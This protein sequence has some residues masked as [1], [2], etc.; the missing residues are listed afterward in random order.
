MDCATIKYDNAGNEKWVAR[1]DGS[2]HLDDRAFDIVV[3]PFYSV[4]ITGSV[5][6]E[7]N[8]LFG[9]DHTD[10]LIIRYDSSGTK[11]WDATFGGKPAKNDVGHAIIADDEGTVY[12]AGEVILSDVNI[13]YITL[14]YD[15]SGSRD[16]YQ[17]W[18]GPSDET[19]IAG[20]IIIDGAYNVYVTGESDS[21]SNGYDYVTIKYDS[22]GTQD[23][24]QRYNGPVDGDDKPSSI[25]V[26]QFGS[27]YVTGSSEGGVVSGLDFATIKYTCGGTEE[28]V[29][30][31]DGT[32]HTTDFGVTVFPDLFGN[33]YVTGFTTNSSSP[34]YS[35]ATI[36]Y[37]NILDSL[38]YYVNGTKKHFFKQ[39]DVYAFRVNDS[40]LYTDSLSV[41]IIDS[42]IHR[43][44]TLRGYNIV[45]FS[46][47]SNLCDR[48]RM[49]DSIEADSNF[50]RSFPI[51]TESPYLFATMP[52]SN[53][54]DSNF[55]IRSPND[56][57]SLSLDRLLVKFKTGTSAGKIDT[58]TSD[59][60]LTLRYSPPD[61]LGLNGF[62]N[63]FIDSNAADP[64]VLANDI[65]EQDS[66]FVRESH[67]SFGEVIVQHGITKP[68]APNPSSPTCSNHYNDDYYCDQWYLE[69][70]AQGIGHQK[71]L[72]GFSGVDIDAPCA[73]DLNNPDYSGSGVT[74]AVIDENHIDINHPDL[75][76]RIGSG[77]NYGIGTTL[78]TA[79]S[80]THSHTMSVIGVIA[81]NDNN[82]EGIVGIAPGVTIIP[83]I[84]GDSDDD[85]LMAFQDLDSYGVDIVNIS[86]QLRGTCNV[87]DVEDQIN[88]N[89]V[90]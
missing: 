71:C 22:S 63:Y 54:V 19:D 40:T 69:N 37:T 89:V 44:D 72:S 42:I 51:V 80:K 59:W 53:R 81:A 43:G 9:D 45:Y 15:S 39:P 36:K 77:Y 61:D 14:K 12:V 50:Q 33:I 75:S 6:I 60:S 46:K 56:I 29:V 27:I 13:D 11:Q 2:D 87:G 3:D 88:L 64:I 26:D 21:S 86:M 90:N 58:F 32:A 70:Y 55:T 10:V 41:E 23:W 16:W 18:D 49:I 8:P 5:T 82:S 24:L 25:M 47:K 57:W 20:D 7:V 78:V 76:N 65:F 67:P 28:W 31:F 79:P 1:Y 34:T 17:T 4:Y 62:Y 74:I 68:Y 83:L 30:R 73:W 35:I 66:S 52:D 85:C 38:F 48:E 84:I